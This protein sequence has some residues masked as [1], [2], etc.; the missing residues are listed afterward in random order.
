MHHVISAAY[1]PCTNGLKQTTVGFLSGRT[2]L[3]G[4]TM[5]VCKHMQVRERVFLDK[6]TD[7]LNS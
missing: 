1:T 7:D 2:S 5:Y 6:V 3:F 4:P